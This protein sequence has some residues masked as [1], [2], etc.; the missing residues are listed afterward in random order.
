VWETVARDALLLLSALA[1]VVLAVHTG[2]RP[3]QRLR[4]DVAQ[5]HDDD[6]TPIDPEQVPKDVRPLVDAINLHMQRTRQVLQQQRAFIDD[7][8]H[9]LRTPL[10][11]LA[12]QTSYALRATD[13]AQRE[14]ALQAIKTQ[15]D[16]AIRQT[17]QMLALARADAMEL[18]R[19][20]L[21]LMAL[22]ERVTRRL[23][24]LARQHGIDLGLEPLNDTRAD[25]PTN[26]PAQPQ[27]HAALLEE[28]LANLLHNALQHTPAGGQVTVQAGVLNGQAV[29]RVADTGP[30]IPA[31]DRARV[32]Q[33]FLR[34]AD[35]AAPQAPHGTG[36]GLAIA[37]AIAQRHG[38]S[39][40]LEEAHPGLAA[41][42]LR[43]GVEWPV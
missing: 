31:T 18:Q 3:L 42:G 15:V 7:A 26:A 27:G 40:R 41:P 13:P 20:P 16:D 30:G 36:L 37:H 23:W 25:A 12:T 21:D 33:R 29:L 38:G 5:R 11:T 4:A 22:A 6:L 1:L 2:L 14:A 39:L 8:S 32:G 9:Q 35:P 34:V 43:V 10:T 28:A 17:N 19:E 24:P